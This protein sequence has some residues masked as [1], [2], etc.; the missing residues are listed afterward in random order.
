MISKNTILFV[1]AGLV[2]GLGGGYLVGN[3]SVS[4]LMEEKG[5][6]EAE[7][8]YTLELL[9]E[10]QRDSNDLLDEIIVLKAEIYNL[11]EE[12]D[13]L[14]ARSEGRGTLIFSMGFKTIPPLTVEADWN[15]GMYWEIRNNGFTTLGVSWVWFNLTEVDFGD[16]FESWGISSSRFEPEDGVLKPGHSIG[17]D[18]RLTSIGFD[19]PPV[20]VRGFWETQMEGESGPRIKRFSYNLLNQNGT[21]IDWAYENPLPIE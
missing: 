6:L 16:G 1:I 5:W 21:I 12:Y 20:Q 9:V 11:T 15:V 4:S 18:G 8:D 14:L 13:D 10:L 17:R 7:L 19:L 2:V 3:S